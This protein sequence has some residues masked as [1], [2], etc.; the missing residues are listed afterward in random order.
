[1]GGVGKKINAIE[2]L[3]RAAGVEVPS[4]P[5]VRFHSVGDGDL[6]IVYDNNKDRRAETS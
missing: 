6:V 1:M 3:P 5:A 4:H 2:Q